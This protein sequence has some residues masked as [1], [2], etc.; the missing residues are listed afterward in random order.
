[1]RITIAVCTWNRCEM[2]R[3][4]LEKMTLL[5]VPPNIE[6]E[7][8]VVNN[9]STDS[10]DDVVRSFSDQ[11]PIKL[12]F[13]PTPGL[14]QARNTAVGGASGDYILWTDDDVLVHEHWL[15][16]YANAFINYPE[17]AVF[18]GPILPDFEGSPPS[19]LKSAFPIV[20]C[21]FAMRD[22]CNAPLEL[23]GANLPCGA[24]MAI[25]SAEQRRHLFD[26]AL[27]VRPNSRLG[28]EETT[29]M[30][31]ILSSGARGYWVPNATVRHY[32]PKTRQTRAFIIKY[33]Y[34]YGQFNA[35]TRE[36]D[37]VALLFGRPRWIYWQALKSAFLYLWH[38]VWSP[39][40]VWIKHLKCLGEMLGR[41][42]IRTPLA[43]TEK[44]AARV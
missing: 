18:G 25:R 4:C 27:G 28:G 41:M 13:E 44:Q 40:E 32:L 17:A 12:L 16:E 1:M 36:I 6:W 8:I 29:V 15:S 19:W 20:A 38:Q 5:V 43:T 22:P 39:S 34:G 42:S 10:T 11:L 35:L 33:F 24:N 9:N 30:S 26:A 2:L 3:R 31:D 7:L 14:S 37:G 23:G 21:C